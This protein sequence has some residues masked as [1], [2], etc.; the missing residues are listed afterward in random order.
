MAGSVYDLLA[1]CRM[2]LF[3]VVMVLIAEDGKMNR[4]LLAKV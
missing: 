4:Q 1:L 3:L 2:R